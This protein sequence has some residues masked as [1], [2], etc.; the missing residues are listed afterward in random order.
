MDHVPIGIKEIHIDIG[1]IIRGGQIQDHLVALPVII[2]AFLC[3]QPDQ[4]RIGQL[5]GG[6]RQTQ[7]ADPGQGATLRAGQDQHGIGDR[8]PGPDL[9]LQGRK[10]RAAQPGVGHM[11]AQIDLAGVRVKDRL[12]PGARHR[13]QQGLQRV[14]HLI[15]LGLQVARA[16]ERLNCCQ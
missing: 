16:H 2:G 6:L 12:Q 8:D 15:G 4:H 9:R 13:F 11:P 10:D 14:A 1:V 5:I 7:C 3:V